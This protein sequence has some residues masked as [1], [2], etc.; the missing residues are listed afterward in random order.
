MHVELAGEPVAL[1]IWRADIGRTRLY[2][3]DANVET[4]SDGTAGVTDK[5]YVGYVGRVGAD[6]TRNQNR[7][8]VHVEY[9]LSSRWGIDGEYGDVGTGSA[10]LMWKKSY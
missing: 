3:L 8:A 7:N 9:Q 10:D 6:P 5:L 2:L 4:N 1:Q